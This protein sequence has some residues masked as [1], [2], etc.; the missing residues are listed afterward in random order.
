MATMLF[1]FLGVVLGRRLYVYTYGYSG[2]HSCDMT[3]YD[4]GR[5]TGNFNRL[6]FILK[7]APNTLTLV[8]NQSRIGAFRRS[9]DA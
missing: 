5:G 7:Y 3:L 6:V 9:P 8:V 4:M 2:F 1:P